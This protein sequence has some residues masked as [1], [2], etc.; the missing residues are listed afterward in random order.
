TRQAGVLAN[1]DAVVIFALA[2]EIAPGGGTKPQ[3]HLGRHGMSI[4]PAPDTIGTKKFPAHLYLLILSLSSRPAIGRCP[5]LS[6]PRH[7]R[8]GS[9][10]PAQS[11]QASA[12][13]YRPPGRPDV[14]PHRYCR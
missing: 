1:D 2:T 10:Y 9:G 13:V 8:G 11:R 7:G 3:R 12:P 6:P 14:R 4:C 5:A